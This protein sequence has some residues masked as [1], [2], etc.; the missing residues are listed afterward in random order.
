MYHGNQQSTNLEVEL[1]LHIR[2]DFSTNR[3]P[4]QGLNYG[5]YFSTV[6]DVKSAV[7]SQHLVIA[8]TFPSVLRDLY[9][10]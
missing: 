8:G 2:T 10:C 5:L 3:E 1:N 6:D 4:G 7:V 9:I